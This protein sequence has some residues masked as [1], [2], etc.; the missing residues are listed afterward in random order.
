MGKYSKLL[1]EIIKEKCNNSFTLLYKVVFA[2]SVQSCNNDLNLSADDEDYVV[3]LA[4]D[5]W[6]DYS[7]YQIDEAVIE[8]LAEIQ[9]AGGVAEYKKQQ[10]SAKETIE[11]CL[12]GED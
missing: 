2:E 1:D 12:E 11:K 6:I 8:I 3:D 7:D 5:R 9:N 10:K 4:Y